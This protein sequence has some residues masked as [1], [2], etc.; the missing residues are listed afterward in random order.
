ME[1]REVDVDEGLGE[2]RKGD[3][4]VVVGVQVGEQQLRDAL[5]VCACA[6]VC[7]C[8]VFVEQRGQDNAHKWRE[9]E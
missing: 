5:C 1:L 6:R 8:V 4:A 2:L 3:A 7:V 9:Y